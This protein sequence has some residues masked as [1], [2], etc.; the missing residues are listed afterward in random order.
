MHLSYAAM[1]G[2]IVQYNIPLKSKESSSLNQPCKELGH[3][4]DQKRLD[5]LNHHGDIGV[6]FRCST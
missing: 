4:R 5:I 1:T 3:G 2:S 6:K